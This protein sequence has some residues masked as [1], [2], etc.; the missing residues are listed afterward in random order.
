MDLLYKMLA[1]GLYF[2]VLLVMGYDSLIKK[3]KR[4]FKKNGKNPYH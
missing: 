3:S 1:Y 2:G 4:R